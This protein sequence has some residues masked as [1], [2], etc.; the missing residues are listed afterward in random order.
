MNASAAPQPPAARRGPEDAATSKLVEELRALA[1]DTLGRGIE[2]MFD[3]ADDML[4]EMARRASNNKDQRI[5][6]DTMRVVRLGRPKI[7]KI[8]REEI[9][10]GFVP[11]SQRKDDDKALEIAFENLSLQESKSLEESIAISTMSSKAENLYSHLLFELGRRIEWLIKEHG[12]AISTNALA[13][14]TISAAFR[15]SA[16]ALDVEFDIELVIFKLFD[17]LV[18]SDLGELYSRALR[19]LDENGVKPAPIGGAGPRAGLTGGQGGIPGATGLDPSQIPAEAMP[20]AGLPAPQGYGFA[21]AP[22]MDAAT[23]NALRNLSGSGGAMAVGAPAYG[24]AGGG[25]ANYY[26]D[27]QLGADLVAVASGRIVPGWEAPRAYAYVQRAGAVGQMFNELMQDPSLPAPLK[28]RFD[29]L[30]FSVIKSALRDTSFF[31]DRQHP[32]RGLMNE[33][34]TLA[35]SARAS[36]MDALRRIEEL[37][38]Q[39]QGQFDVA[40]D[41]VRSQSALPGAVDEKTLEQFFAQQKED[42]RQRRQIIIERTRRVVAEEL[43][44]QT[45]S[46]KIPDAVW[47]LLNSGWAPLAA[48]CLLKLG[49]DSDGWRDAMKLL[50]RVLDSVDIRRPAARSRDNVDEL[51]QDLADSFHEIGMIP[52]RIHALLRSWR[53]G[54]EEVEAAATAHP[55]APLPVTTPSL[56]APAP[57]VAPVTVPASLSPEVPLDPQAKAVA[58]TAALLDEIPFDLDGPIAPAEH[59]VHGDDAAVAGTGDDDDVESSLMPEIPP[60]LLTA[61]HGQP[62]ASAAEE[63]TEVAGD[64]PDPVTLLDL[65]MVLSSWF[66]VY[67]HDRGQNRWLKVIAHHP[68]EGTVTFA[69]FNGQNKLQL[70]TQMFLDDLVAGRAEPIDLGP[71]AR[72]S[73]DAYLNA[74]RNAAAQTEVAA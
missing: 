48:L 63:L 66:R 3:G 58:D 33:L 44:L 8:F 32:V 61:T 49:G 69:E 68:A 53:T 10:A 13:P 24:G 39:I 56:D 46:R 72:R 12:A 55:P 47:P 23:L 14:A 19:F 1:S 71:A 9:S 2:R 18:I 67:D 26:G 73:L 60:E 70:R 59:L 25:G 43:Q 51:A 28:P 20:G 15:R 11:E 37:V 29:Q 62:A 36:G 21:Q 34:T 65:L 45:L 40:A 4:F 42:A 35:A 6:F 16:E 22:M 52:D 38:G 50:N 17:R 64:L 57:A 31:A 74:R 7:G 5:Y 41:D 54:I 30:R 27:V